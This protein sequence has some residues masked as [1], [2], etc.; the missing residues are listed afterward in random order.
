ML[1]CERSDIA[2]CASRKYFMDL[3]CLW[4][5]WVHRQVLH[6]FLKEEDYCNFLFAFLDK[7]TISEKIQFLNILKKSSFLLEMK[8]TYMMY[9]T[10]TVSIQH[11]RHPI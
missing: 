5:L 2:L 6:L 1:Y 9:F 4:V 10:I 7:E 8:Y 11:I 3:K